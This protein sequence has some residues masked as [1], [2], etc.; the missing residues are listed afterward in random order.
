MMSSAPKSFRRHIALALLA[1]SLLVAQSSEN[2]AIGQS[3]QEG[4]Q[5]TQSILQT[6]KGLVVKNRVPD[7]GKLLEVTLPQPQEAKLKNGFRVLLIPHHKVPILTMRLVVRSGGLSDPPGQTGLAEFTATL[8]REGTK[9]RTSRQITDQLDL[10]GA[11]LFGT[12]GA[13]SSISLVNATGEVEDLDALLEIFADIV[14]NPT[15]K[16]EEI[17][18][19][20]TRTISVE[21]IMRSD[22]DFL[23]Q[24]RFYGA[25]Y[26][27]HHP[28]GKVGPPI[29][30][31][32]KITPDHLARFHAAH[33]RPNNSF[34]IIAGDLMMKQ[35]LPVIERVFGDWSPAPVPPTVKP[36]TPPQPNAQV[37]LVNRPDSVQ[38]VIQVGNLGITHVHED[39]FALL[40][41][42]R[43]LGGPMGRL[44]LN[45]REDKGYTYYIYSFATGGIDF[46]G[47]W[48][49]G[50]SVRTDAT[51]D[52][53]GELMAEFNRMR[54]SKVTPIELENAKRAIIGRFAL[55][56]ELPSTL[57]QN[58]F[59]KEVFHLPDDYWVSYPKKVAVVTAEDVQRVARKYINLEK[60]Q[61]VAVGDARKIE[62]HLKP[63]G[64]IKTYE[65]TPDEK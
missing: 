5:E 3:R 59:Q 2:L 38:T 49:T 33:Y 15:F 42:N 13:P 14:R 53:M 23:A 61:V 36:E 46:P 16:A 52:A 9:A 31:L 12:A 7:T 27:Q 58:T 45:L 51:A 21:K 55:S 40:V 18:K 50:S 28:A 62:K 1:S 10:M 19:Y 37:H 29:E 39:Y 8:L 32:K 35:L 6:T 44:F 60:L 64:P 20:L 43:I 26:G 47:V 25:I 11:R 48:L 22:P 63:F 24:Q 17:G 57:L 56:L 30:T 65:T 54:D 34:L 41:M 4:T